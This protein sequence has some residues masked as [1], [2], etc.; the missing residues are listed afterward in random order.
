MT[1]E[2][3]ALALAFVFKSQCSGGCI[4]VKS[5]ET[6][7]EDLACPVHGIKAQERASKIYANR[8]IWLDAVNE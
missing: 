6:L 5:V 1:K 2:E 3:H 4:G 7:V 8:Q